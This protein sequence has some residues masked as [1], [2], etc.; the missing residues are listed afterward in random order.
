MTAHVVDPSMIR[1]A[2]QDAKR[3]LEEYRAAR[4]CRRRDGWHAWLQDQKRDGGRLVY[5]WL[6]KAEP[7]WVPSPT[8]KQAQLDAAYTGERCLRIGR[9]IKKLDNARDADK[10][11]AEAR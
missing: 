3:H 6:R 7:S 4:G 8:G 10:A 9:D 2:L 5:S 11:K 1:N